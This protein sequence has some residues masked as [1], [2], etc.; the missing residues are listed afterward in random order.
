VRIYHNLTSS[1]DLK[2][3]SED[4]HVDLC[5]VTEIIRI[6]K[7]GDLFAMTWRWVINDFL[8]YIIL[9]LKNF[10]YSYLYLT[11]WLTR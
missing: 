11:N 3:F 4:V 7:L 8:I 6:R 10:F 1:D 2:I 5:N 9:F